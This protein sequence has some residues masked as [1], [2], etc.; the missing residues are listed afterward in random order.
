VVPRGRGQEGIEGRQRRKSKT[1]FPSTV[2]KSV[3]M[4]WT[5]AF[6][7][8]DTAVNPLIVFDLY[9]MVKLEGKEGS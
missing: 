3:V 4:L 5:K 9:L 8:N 7:F 2:S 1:H 6:P